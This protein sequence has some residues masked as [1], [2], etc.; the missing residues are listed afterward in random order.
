MSTKEGRACKTFWHGT[1]AQ[2]G[3]EKGPVQEAN[4]VFQTVFYN[5]MAHAEAREGSTWD[6]EKDGFSLVDIHQ[7]GIMKVFK[8]NLWKL[9][10]HHII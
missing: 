9:W 2:K 10:E 3:T 5:K 8:S 6:D 4:E 7:D 1:F